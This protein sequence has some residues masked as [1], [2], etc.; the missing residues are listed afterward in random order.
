M[1]LQ[2]GKSGDLQGVGGEDFQLKLKI[3]E[4]EGVELDPFFISLGAVR[5][6]R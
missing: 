2:N 4:A 5:P 6:L 3:F 1:F